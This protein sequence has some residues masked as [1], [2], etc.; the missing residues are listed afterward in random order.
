MTD[1]Y[2]AKALRQISDRYE[3]L[4]VARRGQHGNTLQMISTL[5]AAIAVDIEAAVRRLETGTQEIT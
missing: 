5:A 4:A 3:E 1:Y 2:S